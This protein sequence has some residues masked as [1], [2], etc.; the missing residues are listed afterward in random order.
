[1]PRT[2]RAIVS[3]FDKEGLIPFCR[4]LAARGIEILSTGGTAS[5]LVEAGVAVKQ[6][7]DHTGSPEILQGR[8]KTLHPK[9]HGGILARRADPSHVKQLED[10]GISPID[11]VAVNLYPFER[12]VAA[13]SEQVDEVVEMIDIGGPSMIR[14]AAKNWHDVTVV[15]D[16]ADYPTVLAEIEAEG[17]VSAA[18]RRR[19][20]AKAFAHTAYY[21]SR[22][23]DYFAHIAVDAGIA[24][25]LA[26]RPAGF[27][28][29][30]TIGLRKIADL[31]YGENPHQSAALYADPGETPPGG[32]AP[33][34]PV[35]ARQLQG[36]EL[37]FNN[38]LDL[39]AAWAAVADLDGTGCVIVKHT[40]PSGAA[41]AETLVEAYR[42]ARDGDPVSAFGGIVAVNRP[43]DAATAAEIAPLFLEAIIAP[44]FQHG[45]LDALKAR[46]N[47]RLMEVD[48][49]AAGRGGWDLKRVAGGILVQDRDRVDEAPAT[50]RTVTKRAPAAGEMRSLLFAW[51]VA[52]HVKSNAIVYARG[53]RTV[54]IGAGQ[55]SR[56]DSA[57]IGRDKAREDLVGTVLASDA[58]FPFRDG[59]DE[60]AK[61]GVAAIIQ[62]GGSVRDEEVIAAADE[63]GIAML[64][65]GRRHF[66][67]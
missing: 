3:V 67:H 60:A 29:I 46:K 59:V 57:K 62:P 33:A 48:G 18:T 8:V 50:F 63:H 4:G 26:A 53:T 28:E 21:D 54:G 49:P 2:A 38:I 51:R 30:L 43:L 10:H 61:A 44:S 34:G 52:R 58:F 45:A 17:E 25:R 65:T 66:R 14:S 36:K 9:V 39:D 55:M 42:F 11:L 64:F 24:P 31:R 6:V 5:A 32:V 23:A 35:S 47:L 13:K 20:A 22:I 15:T 27:P 37:S 7:S 41:C 19:L 40:T 1:M 12:T 16:P 56:V